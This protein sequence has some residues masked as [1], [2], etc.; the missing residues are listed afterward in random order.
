MITEIIS[1]I[2]GARHCI[3]KRKTTKKF[4]CGCN[5]LLTTYTSTYVKN[6]NISAV[7]YLYRKYTSDYF[8]VT[9][10]FIMFYNKTH[11]YKIVIAKLNSIL[12]MLHFLSVNIQEGCDKPVNNTAYKCHV[13]QALIWVISLSKIYIQPA[14][15]CIPLYRRLYDIKQKPLLTQHQM[16]NKI[17]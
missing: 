12:L 16:L 1:Q 7:A 2:W 6:S 4:W 9:S 15:S 8:G 17:I 10:T 5:A 3:R 11:N 14:W 13:K